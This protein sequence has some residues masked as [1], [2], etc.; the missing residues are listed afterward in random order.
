[1]FLVLFL[2]VA[3]LCV[4]VYMCYSQTCVSCVVPRCSRV[5]CVCLHVLLTDLCFLCCSSVLCVCVYMCYVCVFTC[6]THR[7]VFL[8]LF[9]GVAVLCVCVYMCYSQTCVSCAVPRCSRVMCVCL[10]VLLTDLCFLCC[11]SV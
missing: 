11:S 1:M 6:V 3:V 4:C 5:M 2:G 7:L 8:V 9:L 10:H